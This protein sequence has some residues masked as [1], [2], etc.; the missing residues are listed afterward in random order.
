MIAKA[1]CEAEFCSVQS[2]IIK[3]RKDWQL[4]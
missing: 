3:S 2:V 4:Y 1:M